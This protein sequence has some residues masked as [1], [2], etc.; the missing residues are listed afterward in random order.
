MG[1]N[2]QVIGTSPNLFTQSEG[3]YQLKAELKTANGV[4]QG[5]SDK[6]NISKTRFLSAISPKDSMSYCGI[7]KLL[8]QASK[9]IGLSYQ[10]E[11]K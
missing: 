7:D 2:N 8:F 10:W 11:K 5:L 6:L 9:E 1:K 3:V 4:C